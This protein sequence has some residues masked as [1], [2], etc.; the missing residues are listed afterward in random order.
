M[1]I[2]PNCKSE[3][4]DRAKFCLNCGSKILDDKENEIKISDSAI[5]RS[6]IGH[7]NVGEVEISPTISQ[8][9]KPIITQQVQG[10][11]TCPTCGNIISD[12]NKFF[13]ENCKIC[14]KKICN[15]CGTS[16]Y[17]FAQY[18]TYCKDKGYES[19]NPIC[20]I[21]ELIPNCHSCGGTGNCNGDIFENS[22][23][24]IG[25]T[26]K[27]NYGKCPY[28]NGTGKGFIFKCN[29]CNGYGLCIFCHG[30]NKCYYCKGIGYIK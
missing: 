9:F 19:I 22:A 5:Q 4:P 17:N 30:T 18:N 23:Q 10:V 24:R 11:P 29:A 1:V 27:C 12:K 8:S 3:L 21:H 7:G 28:C 6:Q 13:T 20:K 25:I 15:E 2:C 16:Q 14:G 26:R